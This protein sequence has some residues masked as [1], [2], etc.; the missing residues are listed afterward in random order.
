MPSTKVASDNPQCSLSAPSSTSSVAKEN[1]VTLKNISGVL[2]LKDQE[3]SRNLSLGAQEIVHSEDKEDPQDKFDLAEKDQIPN[4]DDEIPDG[5]LA[6]WL[7]VFGVA[8][9]HFFG[10][11]FTKTQGSRGCVIPIAR[12]LILSCFLLHACS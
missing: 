5:G 1:D 11:A 2:T 8:T 3:P 7:V 9:S 6:A 10:A 4:A 12:E